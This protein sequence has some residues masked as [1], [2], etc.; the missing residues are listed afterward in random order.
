MFRVEYSREFVKQ[1]RRKGACLEL[2]IPG[3]MGSS[4]EGKEHV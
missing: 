1:Y 3:S 4:I 2:N